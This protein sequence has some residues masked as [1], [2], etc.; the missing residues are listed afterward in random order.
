MFISLGVSGTK[1]IASRPAFIAMM[2]ALHGDGI[3]LVLVESLGRLARD[4]MVQESILHDLKRHGFD[5]VSVTEPDLCSDDPSRKLMRQ[6]MGA[7]HEYEKQ[8]IVVKLRGARQRT[9]T[10]RGRCEGRKPYGHHPGEVE[11]LKRMKE[12]WA[13]G[14]TATDIAATLRAEGR[15]SRNGGDWLQPTVSKILNREKE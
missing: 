11:T 12:L 2:E 15:R 14:M 9:K 5:L 3:K 10:K 13:A 8:M 4:L 1:D 7:F 6:I